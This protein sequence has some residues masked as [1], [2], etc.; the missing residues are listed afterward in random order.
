MTTMSMMM[1]MMMQPSHWHEHSKVLTYLDVRI[2]KI[3]IEEHSVITTIVNVNC[4]S[5]YD[6]FGHNR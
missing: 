2:L 1:M 5:L 6:L 4:L 3:N